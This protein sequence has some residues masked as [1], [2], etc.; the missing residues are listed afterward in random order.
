MPKGT[1][2]D[3]FFI[4]KNKILVNDIIRRLKDNPLTL[5]NISEAM[6][7]IKEIE[8]MHNR[9]KQFKIREEAEK[10]YYG[11]AKNKRQSFSEDEIDSILAKFGNKCAICSKDEGL[12]IHHK[13][14]NPSNNQLDNLIVLCSICHKKI[15][16]KVR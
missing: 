7:Y 13:D 14:R 11:K 8:K 4:G 16:M 10:K 6:E 1:F 9:E 2:T 12:H 15:H 5:E 3:E